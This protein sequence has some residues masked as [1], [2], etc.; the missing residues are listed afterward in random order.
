LSVRVCKY[1]KKNAITA[2]P[3]IA[4]TSI[5]MGSDE[6]GIPRSPAYCILNSFGSSFLGA[7]SITGIDSR[8]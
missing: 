8:K 7:P 4:D 2:Y 6:I 5:L 1:C 3:T